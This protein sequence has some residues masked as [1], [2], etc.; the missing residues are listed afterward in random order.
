MSKTTELL[1][2]S[3]PQWRL[4]IAERVYEICARVGYVDEHDWYEADRQLR[5]SKERTMKVPV[6]PATA[7][8]SREA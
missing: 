1:K 7:R 4:A 6:R 5:M 8:H 2:A 3:S